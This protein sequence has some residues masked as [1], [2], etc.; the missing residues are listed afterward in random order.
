MVTV[1]NVANGCRLPTRI[2]ANWGGASTEPNPKEIQ[3]S[4]M[5]IAG[6]LSFPLESI[7]LPTICSGL[8]PNI[9]RYAP[10]TS[11]DINEQKTAHKNTLAI[12][13]NIQANTYKHIHR[14]AMG[15]PYKFTHTHTRAQAYF[16]DAI[17][18]ALHM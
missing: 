8:L 9:R 1:E 13:T 16:T 12:S 2:L 14:H 11:T 4:P 18:R 6:E 7:S 3:P 15:S 5:E 10:R 17:Y